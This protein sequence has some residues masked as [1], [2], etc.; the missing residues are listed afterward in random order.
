[1]AGLE[2]VGFGDDD[3]VAQGT[4]HATRNGSGFHC[5]GQSMEGWESGAM[6]DYVSMMMKLVDNPHNW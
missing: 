1:M 2:E 3:E 4:Y 6:K 5:A